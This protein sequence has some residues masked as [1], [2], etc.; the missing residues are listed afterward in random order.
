MA[1]AILERMLY[2][3]T[4]HG[5]LG[6]LEEQFNEISRRDGLLRARFYYWSQVA[7]AM[8]GCI[9]NFFYWSVVMLK[10]YL[11][12]AVRNISRHKTFSLINVMGLAVGMACCIL[13]AVY[14]LTELGYDRYHENADR[15][16]R[17]EA[18]LTLGTQPN[19][20]ASTNMPPT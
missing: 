11:T 14:I 17:L 15:I 16:C 6:D 3:D 10:N 12:V 19:L 7:A 5:A 2:S 9:G 8:P 20:V 4:A 13:I 18:V 1:S